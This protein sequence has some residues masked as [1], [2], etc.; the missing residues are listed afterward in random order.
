TRTCG[1]ARKTQHA[2]VPI[3]SDGGAYRAIVGYADVHARKR[4]RAARVLS[5]HDESLSGGNGSADQDLYGCGIFRGAG[6]GHVRAAEYGNGREVHGS[7][8]A[9]SCG[10]AAVAAAGD[11]A[12]QPRL[13]P[14]TR[15]ENGRLLSASAAL[16]LS[17]SRIVMRKR[18]SRMEAA[19]FVCAFAN[20]G[21]ESVRFTL[22]GSSSSSPSP[23]REQSPLRPR[24]SRRRAMRRVIPFL[25]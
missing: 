22:G 8:A 6:A 3:Y 12:W 19:F 17:G 25:I 14:R 1:S 4:T 23:R 2:P 24:Q 18:N 7:E 15:V 20:R 13:M 21:V 5:G 10:A 16:S 11:G 9:F